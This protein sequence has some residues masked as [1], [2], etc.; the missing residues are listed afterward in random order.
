MK[1]SRFLIPTLREDPQDAQV[2]SHRLMLRAGL[3][4]K[5]GAG[6]YH[7]LPAG[8][9]V[10]RKIESIVREEM[11]RSG[12]LEF[13]LPV[14]IPSDLWEKSGRWETMGKEM[15]R[16]QDRH[17]VWNVLGPT[18]EESF[19]DLMQQILRSYRDLP[20]NVYQIHTKF[21]DEIR[22]RFGVIRSRE[23]IMKDAYSF[24]ADEQSLD[25][26]Y[27]EMRRTYRRIFQRAGLETVPVEADSGAM[28]GS[29]SEEFMVPSEIGEEVLLLSKE[30]RG[31]QEKTP[32]IY[33]ESLEAGADT[34]RP[35][36]PEASDMEP[37]ATPKIKTIEDLAKFL[38]VPALDLLKS[39]LYRTESG[40]VFIGIRGDRD[41][42]EVKL[43]NHLGCSELEPASDKDF[44][45]IGS[46]AGS[47]GPFGLKQADNLKLLFDLS[48]LTRPTWI[49]GGNARDL[50]VKGFWLTDEQRKAAVDLALAVDGDP[51]PAG[52][53]PLKAM[54]GIEVGHIFKLGRKYTDAFK[55][56][57]LDPDQKP[58]TPIMGCYG[59]GINR[60]MA[61][62]IEQSHDDKGII[63]PIS[64][65]PFEI[66]LVSITKTEEEKGRAQE[67]YEAFLNRGLDVLWDD[68][69]LRPGVRFND[70]ELLGYPIRI[71]LGKFFFQE[72]QAELQVRKTGEAKKV[73]AG[74]DF[75]GLIQ[76]VE[77]IRNQLLAELK[78]ED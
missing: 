52:D 11:N 56:T 4:R 42:N 66:C 10:I 20:V 18:H 62:V 5:V 53:G 30:Y 7:L 8:L 58:I 35:K 64:V 61:T 6:L 71:T 37:I 25:E 41:I 38:D 45:K 50:H 73:E 12:A 1:A 51:S 28:G 27:Q 39:V 67:V 68:R 72:D 69:D 9:R 75:Q 65:A 36:P 32:V 26:T 48:A 15:F 77:S 33:E 21:R 23:F 17:E 24:H 44:E 76:E 78:P 54:R 40:L 49:T 43:K 13:Q 22:P 74:K 47:A 14:L 55:M 70:A 2:A 46:V 3:V 34:K 60:T 16:I 31:N 29:G 63:W 59:V 19:T 57:V